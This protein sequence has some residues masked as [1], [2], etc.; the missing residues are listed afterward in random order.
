M[1]KSD[2]ASTKKVLCTFF[3]EG[4]ALRTKILLVVPGQ[5]PSLSRSYTAAFT[6]NAC[7]AHLHNYKDVT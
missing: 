6:P 5:V 2:L 4:S 1:Q 3:V 7:H